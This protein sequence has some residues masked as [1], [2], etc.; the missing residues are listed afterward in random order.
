MNPDVE[1][2]FEP[3]APL[4]SPGSRQISDDAE[5]DQPASKRTG[6][7]PLAFHLTV[8]ILYT[9]LFV[10]IQ[11]PTSGASSSDVPHDEPHSE[12]RVFSKFSREAPTSHGTNNSKLPR[13]R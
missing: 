3:E 8:F 4:L 6:V 12:R 11:L 10:A 9:L 13:R 7:W 2:S 5:H 1:K